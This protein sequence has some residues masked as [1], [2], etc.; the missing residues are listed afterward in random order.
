MLE[1]YQPLFLKYRPQAISELVGQNSVVTTLTNAIKYQRVSHAYLL[2]GPRGTGKTSTARIFA[3]SLNC[4]LGPTSEP[5]QKCTN[6]LEIKQGVSPA[7][8]EIDA[9]SNNSVDDARLLIERA[10]LSACGGRFKLYIIDECHM[11]TKEAFNALLKTIEEPPD[12]VIFI[13]AT[14]E[15]HKVLPTIV[16]RCQKLIF[17]LI[18]EQ[19]MTAHLNDIAKKENIILEPEALTAIVRRANGGLRDGLSLLDQISLLG[20]N[21][22]AIS[23]AD[24]LLLTGALPEDTLVALSNHIFKKEGRDVLALLQELLA[25]GWEAHL[26]ASELAKHL[27]NI[28]KASYIDPSQKAIA[29]QTMTSITGSDKYKNALSELAKL[30]DAGELI[31]MV[32]E[33]DRLEISCRRSAQPIMN[34]EIGL[35]SLCQRLDIVELRAIQSRL[36]KLENSLANGEGLVV[37]AVKKGNVDSGKDKSTASGINIE[38]ANQPIEKLERPLEKPSEQPAEKLQEKPQEKPQEQSQERLNKP[39]ERP[40]KPVDVN[41][42]AEPVA[43]VETDNIDV[44]WQNIL[45]ELQRR[46][47]PTFS[48]VSTHAFP[49]E[50]AADILTIG[51][52]VEN[53]QKMIENKA[54]YIKTAA[55]ACKLGKNLVVRVKVAASGQRTN[56]KT[57]NAQAITQSTD[58]SQSNPEDEAVLAGADSANSQSTSNTARF[59]I[60]QTSEERT[61]DS[62]VKEAYK[63]FEGPGSRY[64]SPSQ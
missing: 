61:D 62:T 24:I 17:R 44:V 59:S 26:I 6:C 28:S 11:L 14:T 10:P 43:N 13:L 45:L 29:S 57:I 9:A 64:I 53:F 30:V 20:G 42:L 52:F 27:L 31:Q 36:D 46:H 22:Q 34:L 1:Q 25:S 51:V 4:E 50:L 63:L 39:Q 2:T 35:L 40:E 55:T 38:K 16:S 41:E 12:N 54:E 19:A 60:R 21:G 37:P 23:T 7:V 32:E 47:L 15:E 8:F 56:N 5:C 58:S 18:N 48:L 49:I 3:K 33:V